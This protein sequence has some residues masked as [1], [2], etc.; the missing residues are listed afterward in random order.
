MNH[1]T[2]IALRRSIVPAMTYL[3][4]FFSVFLTILDAGSVFAS[5]AP[6]FP[7]TVADLLGYKTRDP[8][9]Y[10]LVQTAIVFPW[11]GMSL[12]A[13]FRK[14]RFQGFWFALI[15]FLATMSNGIIL[16]LTQY[17]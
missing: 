3:F 5:P 11:V 10:M 13:V 12:L 6:S 8:V 4:C 9:T 7:R 16:A 2:K 1:F 15:A 14:K 17:H